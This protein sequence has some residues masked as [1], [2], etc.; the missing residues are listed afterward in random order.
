MQIRTHGAAP[1]PAEANWPR[2]GLDSSNSPS[3][4][5]A[6]RL[7]SGEIRFDETTCVLISGPGCLGWAASHSLMSQSRISHRPQPM[8]FVAGECLYLVVLGAACRWKCFFWLFSSEPGC[9]RQAGIKKDV[10]GSGAPDV[11]CTCPVHARAP[12]GT[13]QIHRLP[14][15]ARDASSVSEFPQHQ[16]NKGH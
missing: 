11:R 7:L 4:R 10:H 9:N 2:T 15:V 13:S 1:L 14:R 8:R 12:G 16:N 5:R 3:P 6:R